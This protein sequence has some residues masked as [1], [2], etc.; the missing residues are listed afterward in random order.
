MKTN[1]L[2]SPI[3]LGHISLCNRIVMAPMT[4][5]RA[6]PDRSPPD[7]TVQYYQQRSSAGL[8]ITGGTFSPK[9]STQSARA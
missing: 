3:D 8:I 5:S 7:I 1:S 4:R 9:R 6:L 2:F